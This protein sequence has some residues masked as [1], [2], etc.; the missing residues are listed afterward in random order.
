MYRPLL[1]LLHKFANSTGSGLLVRFI[2]QCN[3]MHHFLKN[4]NVNWTGSEFC[5]LKMTSGRLC[6]RYKSKPSPPLPTRGLNVDVEAAHHIAAPYSSSDSWSCR[7]R[8]HVWCFCLQ[9]AERKEKESEPF[10]R[11][12]SCDPWTG[13]GPRWPEPGGG[14]GTPVAHPLRGSRSRMNSTASVLSDFMSMSEMFLI[15]E[16]SGVVSNPKA[17]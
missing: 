17:R 10:S 8:A 4:G 16:L 1:L 3:R 5:R 6:C 13:P 11:R 12:R 2:E 14:R 15:P 7:C 9:P